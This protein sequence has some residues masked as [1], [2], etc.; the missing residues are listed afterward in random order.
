MVRWIAVFLLL[1]TAS[2]GVVAQDDALPFE[3]VTLRVQTHDSFTYSENVMA[4]FEAETGMKVEVLRSGDAGSMVNQAILSKENPLADV[5]FGVD[6][7]F[8]SRAIEAGIFVPYES[9]L[10]AEVDEA[11]VVEDAYVTPIDYG[12]VALNYDM[13]YFEENELA[14]PD[15]L[16]LLTDEAYRG[17]LVVQNPATSSPGL[18]FLL[19]TIATFGEDGDYTYV[20]YWNDLLDNDVLIVDDWTTAYYTH[21]SLAGGDRPLVVSYASSPPAEV[22]FAD[23]PVED[24]I[25]GAIVADGMAFRQVEYV[26][27]LAGTENEAAAQAF[28]DFLV[29]TTFQEDMPLNM[30]VFPV[31]TEAELPEVFATYA[32]VAENPV[33]VAPEDIEANREDWIRAWT[34]TVRR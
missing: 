25:T 23:P 9:A 21:F 1:L 34:R 30:F 8:L 4:A 20:D 29:S 22:L 16:T 17:L 12:D 7:T 6:N 24:A 33:E 31:N 10:L 14:V 5:L 2:M 28:I 15:S 13:A 18:A 27:I 19:T 11:F 26:G 3:G 32:E